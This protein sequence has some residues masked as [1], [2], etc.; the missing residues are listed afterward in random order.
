MSLRNGV[1]GA[2][3]VPLAD[4]LVQ[5][6]RAHP[7]RKRRGRAGSRVFRLIEQALGLAVFSYGHP[8]TLPPGLKDYGFASAL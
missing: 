4:H 7:D 5:A 3:Q 1:P 6:A 2:G 8:Q